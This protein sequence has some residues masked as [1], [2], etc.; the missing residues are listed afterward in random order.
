MTASR[1]S[2][3]EIAHLISTCPKHAL[4]QCDSCEDVVVAKDMH[5]YHGSM[6]KEWSLCTDCDLPEGWVS[7]WSSSRRR[8]FF[9]NPNEKKKQWS[10]P[11]PGNPLHVPED[12]G[13]C[14][15]KME[16]KRKWAPG[17]K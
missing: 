13:E 5:T 11:T 9:F 6:G 15:P 16:K 10:H 7:K 1:P 4:T 17:G 12:A 2:M 14:M 8:L 3:Q